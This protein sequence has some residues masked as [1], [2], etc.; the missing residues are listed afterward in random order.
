MGQK[1]NVKKNLFVLVWGGRA[2][3]SRCSGSGCGEGGGLVLVVCPKLW[4]HA[5]NT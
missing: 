4:C 2:G 3:G 1:I 5:K